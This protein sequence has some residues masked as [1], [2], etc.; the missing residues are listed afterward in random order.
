[1]DLKNPHTQEE[2]APHE[3]EPRHVTSPPPLRATTT[4]QD[5]PTEPETTKPEE[6]TLARAGR[7]LGLS[8][9]AL[10]ACV[11][12]GVSPAFLHRLMTE[13]NAAAAALAGIDHVLVMLGI[14]A[15]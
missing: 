6:P 13:R 10:A 15:I 1:M 7:E 9:E 8:T 4:P 2:L 14:E 3:Y 11:E 12:H 5:A